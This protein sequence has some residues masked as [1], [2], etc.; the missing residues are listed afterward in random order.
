MST[1]PFATEW[2][3][4][5][6]AETAGFAEVYGFSDAPDAVDL[7]GLRLLP[8]RPSRTLVITMHPAA[9]QGFLPLP[10]ALATAGVHVLCAGNRY[11]RNDTALIMEKAALDLGAY[12]RHARQVWGYDKVVLL[13]W[14]GGGALSLFYQSQAERPTVT[15]TPAGDPL[16]LTAAGLMPADAVIFQAAITSR[17]ATLCSWID[18]SVLDENDPDRRDRELDIY[19]PRNPNQPPYSADFIAAYRAAQ[20]ARMRRKTAWVKET[21]ET[22]RRRGGKE[23]ER[24]FVTHRTM[25][26]LRFM[27]TA[28][29]PND[30][31][32]RWCHLGDPEVSNSGP[33]G[34]GRFSTL[35]AWLSQWSPEDSN[36]NGPRAAAAIAAPLLVMENTADEACPASDPP[37]VFQAAASADKSYVAIKGATH[38][39]QGQP[40]LLRQAA[41]AMLDWLAARGL[42]G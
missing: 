13:G 3:H 33:A 38:F 4:V 14:S 6:Y 40:A 34:L 19:D 36:I 41:D 7:E 12:I 39:Y 27:D 37:G 20:R 42:R 18:P 10:R 24:G 8:R 21:L 1:N 5:R 23:V 17:A 16:D 25:A 15:Q 28:V 11:Y 2:V 22:L 29:D 26:D 30:R 32:A 9:A 35:R 31:R